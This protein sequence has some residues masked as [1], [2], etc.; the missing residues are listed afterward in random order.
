MGFRENRNIAPGDYWRSR[1][2]LEWHPDVS[3]LFARDG[4]GWR[5][6]AEHGTGDLEYT[7]VE[8]RWLDDRRVCVTARDRP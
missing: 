5:A 8:A 1:A 2:V 7:R 3:A 4:L 6:E